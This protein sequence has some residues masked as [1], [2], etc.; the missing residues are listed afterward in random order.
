[1]FSPAFFLKKFFTSKLLKLTQCYNAL[2]I[3]T[4]TYEDTQSSRWN[5]AI[6]A[7]ARQKLL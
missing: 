6:V 2:F 7:T 3:Y 1:M 5:L 4:H